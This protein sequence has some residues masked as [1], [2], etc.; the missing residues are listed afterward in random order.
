MPTVRRR[1]VGA[2]TVAQTGMAWKSLCPL[3]ALIS[4]PLR[5]SA[6]RV[7]CSNRLGASKIA[8]LSSFPLVRLLPKCA[9]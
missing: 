1:S 9:E 4:I 7:F 8:H 6:I 3:L 5:V 2:L